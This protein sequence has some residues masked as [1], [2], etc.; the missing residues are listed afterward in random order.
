MLEQ[1]DNI[2]SLLKGLKFGAVFKTT[3]VALAPPISECLTLPISA[4]REAAGAGFRTQV[5]TG[6]PH[7]RRRLSSERWPSPSGGHSGMNQQMNDLSL[8]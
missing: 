5:L 6:Q 3:F 8:S 7:C 2:M 4:S 1:L